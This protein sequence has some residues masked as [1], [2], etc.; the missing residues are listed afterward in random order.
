[1]T[2]ATTAPAIEETL[3]WEESEGYDAL[4]RLYA[5][6]AANRGSRL[7][8]L[9]FFSLKEA[10]EGIEGET[11]AVRFLTDIRRTPGAEHVQLTVSCLVHP[12]T[13]CRRPGMVRNKDGEQV[14]E[15]LPKMMTAAC[16]TDRIFATRDEAGRLVPARCQIHDFLDGDGRP[17]KKS[18][19]TFGL[20]VIQEEVKDAAGNFVGWQD[21]TREVKVFRD[22]AET[23]ERVPDIQLAEF[24]K[25]NFWDVAVSAAINAVSRRD[26]TLLN[27][28]WLITRKYRGT[29]TK[30]VF[31]A[32]DP[33]M[34]KHPKTGQ[35]VVLDLRDADIMAELYPSV[36]LLRAHVGRLGSE[37]YLNHFFLGDGGAQAAGPAQPAVEVP[38]DALAALREEIEDVPPP[39]PQSPPAA[40]TQPA[41]ATPAPAA[42]TQPAVVAPVPAAATSAAAPAGGSSDAAA[43][44]ARLLAQLN[45]S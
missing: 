39:A 5:E 20:V 16:R 8:I 33:T 38:S 28:V 11:K 2:E 14:K 9:P 36:P 27:R 6:Q 37:D 29:D 32:D 40:V 30:Y 24:G 21:A 34:I 22:G 45:G 18:L 43:T 13:A 10:K 12:R 25:E 44:R 41:P 4:E 7:D 3:N 23:S 31:A 17:V 35:E 26:P 1:M 19:R 42:P 15:K